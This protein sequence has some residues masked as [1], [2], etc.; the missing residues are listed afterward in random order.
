MKNAVNLAVAM[1]E[2]ARLR[3]NNF[4]MGGHKCGQ[5]TEAIGSEAVSSAK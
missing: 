2:S 3:L 5:A 1:G 4:Q